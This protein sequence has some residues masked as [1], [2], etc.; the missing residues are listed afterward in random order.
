M[1]VNL[2][3]MEV[4]K[5]NIN[6]K[7]LTYIRKNEIDHNDINLVIKETADDINKI[8][9]RCRRKKERRRVKSAP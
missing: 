4:W 1:N 3:D 2:N 8:S 7:E 6:F 5:F 9:Q